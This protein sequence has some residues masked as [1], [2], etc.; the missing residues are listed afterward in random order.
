MREWFPHG[1]PHRIPTSAP[2]SGRLRPVDEARR[3]LTEA[4]DLL[5]RLRVEVHEL[6]EENAHLHHRVRLVEAALGLAVK[7]NGRGAM[8]AR[9]AALRQQGL[10]ISRI[11]AAT[12][13]G[14]SS[15]YRVLEGVDVETPEYV[16][17]A[18]GKRYPSARGREN[19][20]RLNG[21]P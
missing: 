17:G 20:R 7:Q 6:R 2:G 18:S 3:S 19:G 15:V 12:G 13:L 9:V 4:R 8:R 1:F 5:S 16:V 14:R 10:S 11:A 21:S